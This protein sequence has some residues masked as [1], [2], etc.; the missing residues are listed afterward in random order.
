MIRGGFGDTAIVGRRSYPQTW[1]LLDV[2]GREPRLV[3]HEVV[4]LSPGAIELRAAARA[5]REHGEP[6]ERWIAVRDEPILH[7]LEAAYLKR[8]SF[9]PEVAY[10][11]EHDASNDVHEGRPLRHLAVRFPSRLLTPATA[12]EIGLYFYGRRPATFAFTS[13]AEV[14]GYIGLEWEPL[15]SDDLQTLI[16]R[17]VG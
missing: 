16:A 8:L 7:R 11:V 10:C 1:Y 3:G 13:A 5:L 6:S 4:D 12:A 17:E 9:G 14:H 15:T 2:V